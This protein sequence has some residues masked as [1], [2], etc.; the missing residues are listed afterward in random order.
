MTGDLE[1]HWGSGAPPPH[2]QK[3][4]LTLQSALRIRP[5]VAVLH[6]QV[7]STADRVVRIDRKRARL[8]SPGQLKPELFEGQLP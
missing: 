5:L 4:A 2:S 1:Q 7:P 8:S 6:P 3:S